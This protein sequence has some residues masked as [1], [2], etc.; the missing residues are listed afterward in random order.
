MK[1]ANLSLVRLAE[2]M[3]AR[4]AGAFKPAR[5]STS[6]NG[7]V[8]AAI[9][10]RLAFS[11]KVRERLYRHLSV[12]VANDVPW[13]TA[14]QT[15]HARLMRKRSRVS[16][17]VVADILRNIKDGRSLATALAMWVPADEAMMIASGEHAGDLPA[18][19]SAVINAKSKVAKVRRTVLSAAVTPILYLVALYGLIWAIGTFFLPAIEASIPRGRITGLGASLY[20]LG[21]FATS[22]WVAIIPLLLVGSGLLVAWS[23]PRWTGRSRVYAEQIFPF[24]FARDING[25]LWLLSFSSLLSAGQ[26]DVRILRQ[27]A[28]RAS[29]WLR[30]RV[31]AIRR[32]MENGASLSQ[33]LYAVGFSFP[34]PDL[35]DDIATMAAFR[36]FPKRIAKVADEWA[37]EFEWRTST[38]VKAAGIVFDVLMYGLIGYVLAAINSMSQQLGGAVHF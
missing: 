8:S 14:L 32:R 30:E 13:I 9:V 21:D 31:V 12:Q 20:V 4:M 37:D 18:A 24:S 33:A 10:G 26:P 1:A 17:G 6:G 16:A 28:M 36:D 2:K 38:R 7:L 25:Y 11:W 19:L 5:K 27:Q 34:N 35:I 23:L 29:P 22:P 15:F 3:S